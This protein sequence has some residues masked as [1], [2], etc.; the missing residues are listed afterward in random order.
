LNSSHLLVIKVA[1]VDAADYDWLMQ[2]KW[3][4]HSRRGL[5]YAVRNDKRNGGYSPSIRMHRIILGIEKDSPLKGDHI[6][7]NTLDNRR[8]NLRIA[9]VSQ[10]NRNSKG[11]RNDGS[12]KGAYRQGKRYWSTIFHNGKAISLGTFSSELEAHLRYCEKAK[13]LFGEF[14]CFE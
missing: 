12:L 10:N 4:A 5:F 9:T 3:Y 14:A 13:E 8:F 1:I 11:K 6:N 2:W 7:H